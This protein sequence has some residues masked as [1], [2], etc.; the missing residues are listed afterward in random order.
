[1]ELDQRRITRQHAFRFAGFRAGRRVL[2]PIVGQHLEEVL[3]GDGDLIPIG[4][5]RDRREG[6]IV[7]AYAAIRV[8]GD[9]RR[10][11]PEG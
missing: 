8:A 11:R 3:V 6:R 7:V 9:D 2:E 1:M 4:I 5:D 10:F